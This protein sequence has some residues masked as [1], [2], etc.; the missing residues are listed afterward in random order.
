MRTRTIIC[1]GF[2][3]VVVICI[4]FLL[5]F[6]MAKSFGLSDWQNG[7]FESAVWGRSNG[8]SRAVYSSVSNII[9]NAGSVEASCG[10]LLSLSTRFTSLQYKKRTP[11]E[12]SVVVS[13]YEELT[14]YLCLGLLKSG[15][16][17]S[18]IG[19]FIL[20]ALNQLR[21]MSIYLDTINDRNMIDLAT[22]KKVVKNQLEQ[23]T[24]FFETVGIRLV[25]GQI[26]ESAKRDFLLKWSRNSSGEAGRRGG[27]GVAE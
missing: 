22:A 8:L 27:C 13:D 19:E 23:Y 2:F 1:I 6:R 17:E 20:N 14:L 24:R 12:I 10:R 26:G 25:F 21:E 15:A 9:I 5:T 16:S 11:R 18:D 3:A 4:L 7:D